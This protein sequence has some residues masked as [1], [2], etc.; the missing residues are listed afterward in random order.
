MESNFDIAKNIKNIENLKIQLLNYTASLF[1]A[2]N[3]DDKSLE[4]IDDIC[5]ILITAYLLGNK[6]GY[7]F[8]EIDEEIRKKIKLIPSDIKQNDEYNYK[9]FAVYLQNKQR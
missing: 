5:N 3:D 8:T 4:L 1:K 6:L 2:F 9:E 7:D